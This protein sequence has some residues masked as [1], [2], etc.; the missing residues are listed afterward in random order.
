MKIIKKNEIQQELEKLGFFN[1]NV[2]IFAK[3]PSFQVIQKQENDLFI[4]VNHTI[5]FIEADIFVF[6]DIDYEI[7]EDRENKAQINPQNLR[8]CKVIFCPYHPHV[9]CRPNKNVT[10]DYVCS[11]LE[12]YFSG[13]IIPYNLHS[14][15]VFNGI[16]NDYY[17]PLQCNLIS[18]SSI[19]AFLFCKELLSKKS[20]TTYGITIRHNK[21]EKKE[22]YYNDV[23]K[24]RSYYT[25]FIN[26]QI[27]KIQQIM[28]ENF[29]I[30]DN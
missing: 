9:K 25:R 3:G 1:K 21:N 10:I 23:F 5:N 30:H 13:I 26:N 11:K 22:Q 19:T 17:T 29:V 28:N 20:V 18:S 15:R 6:N 7:G 4:A 14:A 27:S 24:Q 8:N 12:P 16:I 2:T